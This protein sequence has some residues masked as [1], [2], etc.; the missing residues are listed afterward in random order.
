MTVA[1]IVATAAARDRPGRPARAARREGAGDRATAATAAGAA[2]SGEPPGKPATA[3]LGA[4]GST[5]ATAS[6]LAAEPGASGREAERGTPGNTATALQPAATLPCP[7][8]RAGRAVSEPLLGRLCGQLVTLGI[9]DVIVVAG[10]GFGDRLRD[11][12]W[13]GVSSTGLVPAVAGNAV[14]IDVIECADVA[15]QL[16]A[17]ARVSGEQRRRNE[18]LL[19]CAGDVIAHID[20]LAAAAGSAG[21]AALVEAQDAPGAALFAAGPDLRPAMRTA[22]RPPGSAIAAPRGAAGGR[23]VAAAGS[24]FHRVTAPDAAGCGVFRVAPGDLEALAAAAGQLAVLAGKADAER[25][26]AAPP[27]A[28]TRGWRQRR[29][30]A[31]GDP[32]ALLL[33]GLVRGGVPVAAV[34]AEPLRCVRVAT[35][36]QARAAAG[37]LNAAPEDRLRMNAAV[38]AVDGFVATFLVSPYSKYVARWA[39]R[40][41]VSPH[42]VTAASAG[43]ALI[44]AVW[45]SAGTQAGLVVGAVSVFGMFVLDCV[46]GQVARYARSPSVFG[47]WLDPVSDRVKEYAVYAGLAVGGTAAH[48]A[49]VWGLAIAALIVQAIRHMTAL[50]YRLAS[51]AAAAPE[52]ARGRPLPLDEPADYAVAPSVD[53]GSGTAGPLRAAGR[54]LGQAAAGGARA[55]LWLVRIGYLPA[56]ERFVLIGVTAAVA[57]PRMTFLV[58]L[59]WGGAA[60]VITLAVLITRSLAASRERGSAVAGRSARWPATALAM[61]SYRDDGVIAQALGRVVA[62]QL[63]PLL[64]AIAGVTVTVALA[65]AGLHYGGIIAIAPV[66]AML[67]AGL[68]RAHPHDGR[69]DWLV[70]PLLEAGEYIYLAAVGVS[71]GVPR[72]IIFALLAAI[73]AHHYDVGCRARLGHSIAPPP[74]AVRAGLGWEGRMLVAALGAMLGIAPFAY[75]ALSAYVWIFFSWESLTSWLSGPSEHLLAVVQ[76][77]DLEDGGGW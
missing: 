38:K 13:D 77:V 51:P 1:V 6:E 7:A 43:L 55:L 3:A 8:L 33:V 42:A 16:Q 65:A 25:E 4:G 5:A 35:T 75:V 29:A 66:A 58:L 44:A 26:A 62:G 11:I 39:A 34:S 46:D 15:S 22:G 57:G 60:A 36:Q 2:G 10:S 47:S 9:R 73:A 76:A 20:A 52:Q 41:E 74:W 24:S 19:I 45:F 70:P 27:A 71:A 40:R 17:V 63:P 18:G 53:T 30:S 37:Q 67:L 59:A 56:G 32:V 64:P 21:T 49:G 14:S 69:L 54:R 31:F 28:E 61:A 48:Q 50:S 68:G 23:A 72:P 12:A